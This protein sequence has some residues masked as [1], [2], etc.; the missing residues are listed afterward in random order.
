M[1][2]KA[3]NIKTL[4]DL[5]DEVARTLMGH[6]TQLLADRLC[7]T[8]KPFRHFVKSGT[9]NLT[10]IHLSRDPFPCH[11][12]HRSVGHYFVVDV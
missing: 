9:L 11:E 3:Q 6:I 10:F 7:S 2:K 12:H 5:N 4:L 1:Q 8:Q